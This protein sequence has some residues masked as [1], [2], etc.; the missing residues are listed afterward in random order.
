MIMSASKLNGFNKTAFGSMERDDAKAA[1]VPSNEGGTASSQVATM[2]LSSED[3]R[4]VI[5]GERL[6]KTQEDN[7]G[8]SCEFFAIRGKSV[9]ITTPLPKLDGE[10]YAAITDFLNC[11]FPFDEYDYDSVIFDLLD[12]LGPHFSPVKNRFKGLHGWEQSIQLGETKTF[13]AYGG[14]NST[15]FLSIPAEGCHLV[16]NWLKLT[17]LLSKK[18][19]AKITRWDGAVDDY[20]GVYSVDL[21]VKLYQEG[22]FNAGGNLPA[23]NQNGNWLKPDG[24]GRTFYIGKRKNGKM[25]RIYEKGMQLGRRFHPWVRWELELHSV[26]RIIPW[27]VLMEPGKYVAGSYPNATG[28]IQEEMKRIHTITNA[29]K[30]SYEFLTECA[31]LG[32]GKHI[33][34]MLEVEGSAEKV[35]EKLI[36]EGIPKR[37]DIPLI[38]EDEGWS[39]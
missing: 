19:K 13:F 37:L 27:D 34:V 28:W 24:S 18:F 15:A 1:F 33:N 6:D 16:P 35:V 23:C 32:Y 25:M 22:M 5:R 7:S 2:Q 30:I 31:S 26:D 29:T 4:M 8:E 11:T 21:A 14:Q 39:K 38:P 20:F 10:P 36:R 17:E 3:P 9:A 12:C